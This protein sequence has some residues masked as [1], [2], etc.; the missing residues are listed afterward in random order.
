MPT[1]IVVGTEI[2][3]ID[4]LDLLPPDEGEIDIYY[5]RIGTG[6]TS[7][8]TRRILSELKRGQV[9][10]ANW[11]VKW[12]GYDE[13]K[14]KWKLFLGFLGLKKTYLNFPKENFYY[15]PVKEDFIDKLSKL[16]SCNVHLDEGHIPFDSY[17]ATRME[18]EKRSAVFATRH[19]DRTMTVYTQRANSVHVN[20]RGNSNR[21]FKCEKTFDVNLFGHRF[22]HFLITEF[23]DLTPSSTVDERKVLDKEGNETD[24]YELACSTETYWGT[25]KIFEAYESK[26]LR[27]DMPESQKNLT[28]FFHL[29]WYERWNQFKLLF[30]K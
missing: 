14:S 13:R 7:A 27:G 23:Q 6:K 28:Q 3:E 8:G 5:G 25:K 11:K 24:Q 1:P 22:I 12:E 29:T 4:V 20:L 18:V 9:V 16:T 15:F 2:K 10:Y 30:K 17:E 26:Y 19:F 21:F